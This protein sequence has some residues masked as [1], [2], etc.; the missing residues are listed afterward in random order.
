MEPWSIGWVPTMEL[1]KVV[2][3]D[4][5][6]PINPT[7]DPCSTCNEIST[8]AFTPPKDFETF[9]TSKSAISLK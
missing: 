1:N 4:P 5:F 3:P 8:L 2:L 9:L 7:I 6:G